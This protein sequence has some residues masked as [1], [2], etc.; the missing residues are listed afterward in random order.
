[1]KKIIALVVSLAGCGVQMPFEYY[2]H[3][4]QDHTY[5][6]GCITKHRCIHM[7]NQICGAASFD[8]LNEYSCNDCQWEYNIN[9]HYKFKTLKK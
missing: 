6:I 8:V 3:K 9:L 1:M 7:A 5:Y 4:G 2:K